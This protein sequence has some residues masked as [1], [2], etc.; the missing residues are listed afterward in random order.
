MMMVASRASLTMQV[1]LLIILHYPDEL[2]PG[3]IIKLAVAVEASSTAWRNDDIVAFG[4]IGIHYPSH[5]C[6]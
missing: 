2:P 3:M 1:E 6:F 5:S 4:D